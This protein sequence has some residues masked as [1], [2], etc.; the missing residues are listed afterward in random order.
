MRS[1]DV[2]RYNLVVKFLSLPLLAGLVLFSGCASGNIV[3]VSR[4]PPVRTMFVGT[5]LDITPRLVLT[6][7]AWEHVVLVQSPEGVVTVYAG[8]EDPGVR[9]GD[10]VQVRGERLQDNDV[11][12]EVVLV[13]GRPSGR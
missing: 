9:P 4:L 2:R 3:D 8:D 7:M 13:S 11:A 12:G 10:R 6:E 5:V 1:D